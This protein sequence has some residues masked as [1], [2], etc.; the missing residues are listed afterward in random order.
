M[1]QTPTRQR[2]ARIRFRFPRGKYRVPIAVN[3][4]RPAICDRV[5]RRIIIETGEQQWWRI[6]GGYRFSETGTPYLFFHAQPTSL[7]LFHLR[8][9][10]VRAWPARLVCEQRGNVNTLASLRVTRSVCLTSHSVPFPF[11]PLTN[12]GNPTVER[13]G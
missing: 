9:F 5:C 8:A 4:I 2:N 10:Y 11:I 7:F 1:R 13:H 3:L 6:H 12:A